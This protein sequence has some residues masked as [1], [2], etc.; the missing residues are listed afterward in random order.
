VVPIVEGS[1]RR[2]LAVLEEG[3][4]FGEI[5]LVT[6]QPRNA[7]IQALVDTQLLA[8]DREVM[9]KLIDEQPRLIGVLLCFLRDR[10]IDRLVR[11]S[12]VFQPFARS[13]PSPLSKTNDVPTLPGTKASPKAA[14]RAWMARHPVQ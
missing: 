7:S 8:I 4:F 5:G 11:T 14:A 3:D 10:L 2:K 13:Q 9:W 12:P 1:T 6:D